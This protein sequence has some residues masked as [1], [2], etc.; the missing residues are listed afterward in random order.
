M[1]A[2]QGV[3]RSGALRED[4]L[5]ELRA[6]F[7]LFDGDGDGLLEV[8]EVGT[9][10]AS[11]G[12]VLTEAECLDLVTE[13]KPNLRKL[14]FDEFVNMMCRPMCESDALEEQIRDTFASA[15]GGKAHI[16]A[17]SLVVS[18]A[19]LGQPVDAL[20]VRMPSLFS[21][22]AAARACCFPWLTPDPAKAAIASLQSRL[23][24]AS[25]CASDA[26]S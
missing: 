23:F 7:D 13:L 16:T 3:G 2:P 1:D 21:Y 17:A 24:C 4:Q 22:A 9:L 15:A 19:E 26:A 10:W 18:R 6:V 25:V 11:C 12:V 20:M 5:D 8:D 14:P